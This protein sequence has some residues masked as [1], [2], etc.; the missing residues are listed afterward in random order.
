MRV[1]RGWVGLT[2]LALCTWTSAARAQDVPEAYAVRSD[3]QVD[4]D[5]NMPGVVLSR[6]DGE[7]GWTALGLA[8]CTLTLPREALELALSFQNHPPVRV[9]IALEIGDGA[10]LVGRYESRQTLRELGVGVVLGTLVGVLIG[11]AIGVGALAGGRI[12]VGVGGLVAA[13]S[14]GIVGLATGIGLA[15][16]DD[17]ASI[18]LL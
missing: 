18:A 13:G 6:A 15:T 4:F 14:L 7:G 16:L 1:A 8:P 12:D 17:L 2:L 3:V 5:A 11:L 9:P 10:R